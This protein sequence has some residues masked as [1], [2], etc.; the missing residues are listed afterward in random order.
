MAG[1]QVGKLTI[2][3]HIGAGLWECL[4]AC[5]KTTNR[6]GKNLRTNIA[7]GWDANCGQCGTRRV[8]TEKTTYYAMRTRCENPNS[9]SFEDYGAR[10]IKVCDRW[11][12]SFDN[13]L[14]DMGP[15]PTPQHTIER[16][17]ND[18]GYEPG[19]CKWATRRENLMNRRPMPAALF[20][21]HGKMMTMKDIATAYRISKFV[22]YR[23]IN[24]GWSVDDAATTPVKRPSVA[25]A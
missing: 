14:A 8:P 12:E 3:R 24:N 22:V 19:N 1:Q 6:Y 23:R 21:C 2:K 9:N 25:T 7:N 13:F 4:C 18:K 11:R 17:N 20:P 5:G 10:G 16:I 15:K